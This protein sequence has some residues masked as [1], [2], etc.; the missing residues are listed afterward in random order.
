MGTGAFE[1]RAAPPKPPPPVPH[2]AVKRKP[3]EKAATKAA[4]KAAKVDKV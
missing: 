4:K 1:V 2:V 3:G